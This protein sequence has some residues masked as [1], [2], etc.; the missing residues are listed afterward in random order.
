MNEHATDQDRILANQR[1]WDA[2]TPTHVT[3]EFYDVEGFKAGRDTIDSVESEG[4][5]E[6]AGKTLIHLQCHFGLDTLSWA[7][8]GARVTGV[9]F[10]HRAIETARG[11]AADLRLPARFIES[12]VYR[13]LEHLEGELFD[14]VFTSYGALSWL[15]DLDPWG[16]VVAG[17][18]APGG[19]FF[20][21]E[22]HPAL[23]VYDENVEDAELVYR[24]G[25]FD[26]KA[27]REEITGSYAAP[28]SGLE[29][30]SYSWQHTFEDVFGAL[31]RAGLRVTSLRE[32]PYLAF[33]WF[34]WMEKGADGFWR[35]PQGAPE[36]PLMYSLTATRDR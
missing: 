35:L 21:A 25:Y 8:R 27:L 9:D 3:S 15:P 24:Y 18:L 23:W 34:P 31:T 6:V 14:V 13:T 12:D 1:L 10:S 2:W 11:L 32:F 30:V 16:K 17:A 28:D 7:R 29:T 33:S 19:T 22:H 26:R 20:L 5:G 4:V 36:I